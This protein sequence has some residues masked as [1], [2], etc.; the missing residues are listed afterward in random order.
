MKPLIG[1]DFETYSGVDLPKH[2]LDRYVSDPTFVPLMAR[3]YTVNENGRKE[4]GKFDFV[5]DY[6]ESARKELDETLG[7]ATIAAHNAPFEER[8]LRWMKLEIGH[9]DFIDSAVVARAAGA[10]GSLEAAAPQLLGSD[11]YEP[12]KALMRLFSLPGKYQEANGTLEFDPLVVKHHPLEWEE[13]GKYCGIDAELGYHIVDQWGRI[14]SADEKENTAITHEMN[15]VGWPVD[16][17]MV[18]EMQRRY[19]DNMDRALADFRTLYESGLE[20]QDQL[21]FNSFPQLKKWCEARGVKAKSFDEEHVAMYLAKIQKR[22]VDH[23]NTMK[24]EQLHNLLEVLELMKTKQI[25]GGSSLKKLQTIIDMVGPGDR[26]RGQYLHIGAGQT[27]RTSGKG[28]QMQN[29]KQLREVKDMDE[30]LEEDTDWDNEELARNLRQV[31]TASHPDGRLIVGDF[32]SVESRGLAYLAGAE[33][34]LQAFRAGKDM[35]KVLASKIDGVPYDGVTKQRRQFGK[36]GELSCGYQAGGGAVQRF[37][38]KMGTILTEG[39]ASQLVSDW[40]AS[41]PEVVAFWELLDD[42]LYRVVVEKVGMASK[43]LASGCRVEVYPIVTPKSL[44][45]LHPA[46]QSICVRLID[47]RG[48]TFVTRYFHGCYERGRNI[49][50]YKPTKK[51]TGDVWVNHYRDPKTDEIRFYSIYGGK[52]AGILTQSMCRE[53]FFRSLRVLTRSL[54]KVQNMQIIGQFHDEI[55][56]DWQPTGHS[57]PGDTWFSLSAAVAEVEHAMTD[58]GTLTGFP[59]EA[60]VKYDY[61]YTK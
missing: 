29:L 36:V 56:V 34:K 43:I 7:E 45:D 47:P 49:C 48:R 14:L 40:R 19:L 59:L 21:N 31:F 5:E 20:E 54:E 61:R 27:W 15:D 23:A 30:L 22:I 55:V 42:L 41:N 11:K 1:L 17:E 46:A 12:G 53:M 57:K 50:F 52:L 9:R 6:Y 51:K 16:M 37:A 25:L 13:Y 32:R 24:P 33:W 58:A 2:G 35:Y 44:T 26:L 39:E 10:A 18:A 60:E 8:V 3:T 38:K 28:V 4:L